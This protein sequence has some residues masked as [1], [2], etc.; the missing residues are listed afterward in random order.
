LQWND[1]LDNVQT[2]NPWGPANPQTLNRY[3]Y[4]QNNP[5]KYTDPTG[6]C[7][8]G[9][10]W[11]T[12]VCVT[13]FAKAAAAAFVATGI[14][15]LALLP[16]GAVVL[17]HDLA[18]GQ[19]MTT[20]ASGAPV[21]DTSVQTGTNTKGSNVLE[22]KQTKK[23]SKE[24]KTDIPSWVRNEKGDYIREELAKGKTAKQVAD[25][26]FNEKYG[27]A[28]YATGPGSEYSKTKKGLEQM[29]DK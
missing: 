22:A 8:S 9:M 19:P 14:G 17:A 21:P 5:L 12:A 2:S 7:A 10:T 15:V 1:A 18:D 16:V 29:R 25:S 24:R 20:D 23:T 28:N 26:I 6:H 11:D 3:S 4:V 27:E 13:G